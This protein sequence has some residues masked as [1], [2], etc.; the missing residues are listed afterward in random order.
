MQPKF[1][2]IL[3]AI[4]VTCVLSLSLVAGAFADRGRG[5]DGESHAPRYATATS[6][7]SAGSWDNKGD[8][9]RH[10]GDHEATATPTLTTTP[11]TATPTG[12]EDDSDGNHGKKVSEAAHQAPKGPEHG[13]EVSEVARDNNGQDDD[14]LDLD[15]TPIATVSA[16]ATGTPATST[17]TST[18]TDTPTD[19]ATATPTVTG[20]PP[21][22]TATD[23][24]TSTPTATDTATAT[25]T[26]ISTDTPTATPTSTATSTATATGTPGHHEQDDS[27]V[28]PQ[29][30][31]TIVEIVVYL[32][33]TAGHLFGRS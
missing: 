7:D 9:S 18:S 31:T 23:T 1:Q 15:D 8:S 2:K 5:Q 33:Q 16:T 17:P 21:T 12:V 19:T 14:S 22:A 3:I 25:A 27:S 28:S 4:C 20:T 26:S 24:A 13:E 11:V 6:H 10:G 30:T 29:G 32:F